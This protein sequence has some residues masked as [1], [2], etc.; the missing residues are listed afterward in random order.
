MSTFEVKFWTDSRG[1][2]PVEKWLASLDKIHQKRMFA[3]LRMLGEIGRDL[4]L[5]H[6]RALGGGLYELRDTGR[7]PGYRIYYCFE[8]ENL[9][10]LL[11]SG[12]KT[13]QERDISTALSR[14]EDL[15]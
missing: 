4:H 12:K 8:G 14:M 11:A 2:C 7:G 5:P 9:I 13:S 1:R 10:I 6:C 15:E 3:L